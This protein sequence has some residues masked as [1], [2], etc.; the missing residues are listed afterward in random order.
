MIDI[1]LIKR[2]WIMI[3]INID[4]L[5]EFKTNYYREISIIDENV[6]ILFNELTNLN[7]SI[8]TPNISRKID[9]FNEKYYETKNIIHE[10][11]LLLDSTI[12][13]VIKKYN[14]LL[15]EIKKGVTNDK[16]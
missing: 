5:N 3:N 14:D 12:E 10:N 15:I 13:E 7:E 16:L 9:E 8:N 4:E 1:S 11:S 2:K 6:N